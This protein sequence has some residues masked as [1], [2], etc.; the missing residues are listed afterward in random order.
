MA[1]RPTFEELKNR[2]E[3]DMRHFDG[4]LPERNA[5]VWYGYLAALIEWGQISV[6][7]HE[8]LTK[9][10]PLIENNP[11]I[12]ILLGREENNKS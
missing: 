8:R 12:P 2:I 1:E 7:E 6:D 10:L 11:V 3:R 5:L 9:L 4:T